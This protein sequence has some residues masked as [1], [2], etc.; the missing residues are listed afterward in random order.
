MNTS[1][2]RGSRQRYVAAVLAVT[3]L[4]MIG[5]AS[6]P[7]DI[8]PSFVSAQA[9]E[10]KSCKELRE[11]QRLINRDLAVLSAE[12][13]S[14]ATMDNTSFW[15]GMLLL[16]PATFVPL[17]TEDHAAEI[18]ELKGRQIALDTSLNSNCSNAAARE[19]EPGHG[20]S[21]TLSR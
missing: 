17:F 9:F 3:H 21:P 1:Q 18:R 20:D 6:R 16:W 11:E 2:G 10:G 19:Q 13:D 15:I 4:S 7:A 5:C 8:P 12:Q 14:T